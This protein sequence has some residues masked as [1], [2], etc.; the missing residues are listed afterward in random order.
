MDPVIKFLLIIVFGIMPFGYFVVWIFYRKTII[1]TTALTIFI[2]SMGVAFVSFIIGNKGLIHLTWGI[3]FCLV[4]LVS[5][6]Y[7]TK[8]TV[9]KPIREL[10][11][12][13]D[14][15]LHGNLDISIDKETLNKKNE[16]GE[17][18]KSINY[19]IEQLQKVTHKIDI[20]SEDVA[21]I[22][23]QIINIATTISS[24]A[25]SQA[26]S[27][28][29]LSSS[30][31]EMVANIAQNATNARQTESIALSSSKEIKESKGSMIKT[32]E[33]IKEISGKI[34]I[35]NDIAFQTNILALNAAVEASR[36]GEQGKGF[37]V[38][39]AEVRKLAERSKVAA[40]DI[41]LLSNHGLQISENAGMGLEKIIP[42]I[43]KTAKLVQ[44]ITAASIEQDNGAQQV[45]HALQELNRQS[46]SSALTSDEL[47]STAQNLKLHSNHLLETIN[48]FK[49]KVK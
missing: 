25:N 12:K 27:V 36:A 10:N 22:S 33:S 13:I 47:V 21:K 5:A 39:A 31:E 35:I 40:D 23:N 28:E 6:N 46:Q 49:G 37:S 2:A 30:M 9:R 41:A 42:E 20:S 34:S 32:L 38:V 26:A 1:F 29:Q 45:N 4:W 18:A 44:E 7:F 14:E 8:I 16:I 19:L 15:M 11:F 43:E 17:I 3:P 48:F 24:V